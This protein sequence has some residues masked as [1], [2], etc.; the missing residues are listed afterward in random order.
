MVPRPLPAK[1]VPG[2]LSK[3]V[4]ITGNAADK[5]ETPEGFDVE[6]ISL[7]LV[8]T[9]TL[10]YNVNFTYYTFT[11]VNALKKGRLT[12]NVRPE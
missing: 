7:S 2:E 4:P 3:D 11:V 12:E 10:V 8:Y 6:G 1:F 9:Y 5:W